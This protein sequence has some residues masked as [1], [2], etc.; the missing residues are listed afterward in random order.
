MRDWTRDCV[1][2]AGPLPTP[3]FSRPSSNLKTYEERSQENMQ[4]LH[5]WVYLANY[6][7]IDL[8][9]L[10]TQLLKSHSNS[11]YIVPTVGFR[12][13]LAKAN[14]LKKNQHFK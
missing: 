10:T 5:F 11:T 8:G 12:K 4:S 14:F 13:K 9:R 7:R 1:E 2:W 6:G 3:P